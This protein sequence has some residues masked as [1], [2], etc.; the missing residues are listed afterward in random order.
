MSW[1]GYLSLT[2]SKQKVGTIR[3]REVTLKEEVHRYT[4]FMSDGPSDIPL[5]FA[6]ESRARAKRKWIACKSKYFEAQQIRY[7][8]VNP[9]TYE[10]LLLSVP[11][12]GIDYISFQILWIRLFFSTFFFFITLQ[13]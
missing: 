13:I 6:Y 2:Y 12:A 3:T 7:K 11:S 4:R 9:R 10:P 8:S 1:R 5:V